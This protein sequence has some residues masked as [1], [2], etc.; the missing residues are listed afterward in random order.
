MSYDGTVIL[1]KI[2]LDPLETRDFVI[3]IGAIAFMLH[4]RNF[5]PITGLT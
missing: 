3:I 2:E 5:V 1:I 4:D